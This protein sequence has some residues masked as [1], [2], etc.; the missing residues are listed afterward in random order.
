MI[1][2]KTWA[3]M[4]SSGL[5]F[6][7]VFPSQGLFLTSYSFLSWTLVMVS[8]SQW[9]RHMLWGKTP[10]AI[11]NTQ[12]HQLSS[13]LLSELNFSLVILGK[14]GNTAGEVAPFISRGI[15]WC[16][17]R[18]KN[19]FY[20]IVKKELPRWNSGKGPPCNAGDAG[21]TSSDTWVRKIPWRTWQPT[22]LFLPGKSHEQRS[23][24]G[25]SPWGCREFDMTE[26]AWNN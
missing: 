24:G 25:Y 9:E 4:T 15:I 20:I 8:V 14:G 12:Q 16:N 10:D 5:L 6:T 26:H 1:N 13:L 17:L 18:I 11:L 22:P 21:D 2:R 23:L 3:G 7:W 19:L